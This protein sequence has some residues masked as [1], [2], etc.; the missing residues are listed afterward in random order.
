MGGGGASAIG[1]AGWTLPPALLSNLAPPMNR[2]STHHRSCTYRQ[3]LQNPIGC[4]HIHSPHFCPLP[5]P[6]PL[7]PS[8]PSPFTPW[9]GGNVFMYREMM[10]VLLCLLFW[11]LF[12]LLFFLLWE[13]GVCLY[14]LSWQRGSFGSWD[15]IQ[16][17]KVSQW[18]GCLYIYAI[19]REERTARKRAGSCRE[20][21]LSKKK[22]SHPPRT[23]PGKQPL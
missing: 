22:N 21:V 1:Q 5:L 10:V 12:C 17:R 19:G 20:L 2:N 9:L 13:R 16:Y 3:T 15:G 11:L 14:G 4:M 23:R 8:L 6:L 7:P 18:D